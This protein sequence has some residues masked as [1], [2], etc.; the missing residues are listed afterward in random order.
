MDD[1]TAVAV[2]GTLILTIVIVIFSLLVTI[3]PMIFIFRWLAKMKGQNQAILMNGIPAQARIVQ[4]G[5]T[6]MYVNHAPQL[7]IVLEVHPQPSPGYRGVAAPYNATVQC[8]VPIHAMGRIQP[9]A[10]VPVRFSPHNPQEV[11]IDM[12]SMGFV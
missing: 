11:A 12:R 3:I 6:G 7:S 2:G 5:Q 8:L 4:V 1:P 9:G 10:M